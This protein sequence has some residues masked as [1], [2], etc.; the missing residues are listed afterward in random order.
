MLTG[1]ARG[2]VFSSS[3]RACFSHFSVSVIGGT[4]SHR[5][6]GGI[7]PSM[8]GQNPVREHKGHGFSVIV[9]RYLIRDRP[10]FASSRRNFFNDSNFLQGELSL[11]R[12]ITI[13]TP[14]FDD[15]NRKY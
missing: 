1:S 11:G 15:S 9:S 2:L 14:F 3:F 7:D 4:I 12:T 8:I 13:N 5:W 6:I 10:G